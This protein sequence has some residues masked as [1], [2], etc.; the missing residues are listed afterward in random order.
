MCST[1]NKGCRETQ[2]ILSGAAH[3]VPSEAV[4]A[5]AQQQRDAVVV[6]L[7]R[8]VVERR[9]QVLRSGLDLGAGVQQGRGA[10]GVI[11]RHGV[12][13]RR[14]QMLHVRETRG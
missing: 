1:G 6:P 14:A 7:V 4:R 2:R 9:A 13:Q 10:L 5:P 3:P 11:P 8:G 12:V